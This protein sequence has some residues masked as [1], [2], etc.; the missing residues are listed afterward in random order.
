MQDSWGSILSQ[1][2]ALTSLVLD[3]AGVVGTL[4]AVWGS[5]FLY[6]EQLALDNNPGFVPALPEGE[7]MVKVPFDP[8][9]P[10]KF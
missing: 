3:A 6:L 2:P 1:A 9:C 10:D 8:V 5:T 4:P 7:G